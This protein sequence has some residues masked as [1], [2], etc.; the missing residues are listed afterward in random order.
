MPE[1]DSLGNPEPAEADS[2]FS[3]DGVVDTAADPLT[4]R[5]LQIYYDARDQ[6]NYRASRFL[7][8]VRRDG[9]L[10]AAKYYLR[11]KTTTGFQ[12][13]LDHDRL[14]LSVETVVVGNPR[15]RD[16][17]TP[18]ELSTARDRLERYGFFVRSELS[19]IESD[20]LSADEVRPDGSYVEG[21]IT[22][23]LVNAYERNAG[24]RTAC[25]EEYGTACYVCGFEFGRVY[26]ELGAGRIQ[27]HHLTPL[28]SLRSQRQTDP[29]VDLRPVCANCHWMLHRR[30]PPLSIEEL[31]GI[32]ERQRVKQA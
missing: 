32:I 10:K 18:E 2:D 23:I 28:S 4:Q 25:I 17:F 30:S 6:L 7:A 13:L 20:Q 15:W 9:G 27:V 14:D 29:R 3:E 12:R 1:D 5:M 11:A 16:Y 24:A 31:K 19:P 26:G 22:Q 8:K 21:A